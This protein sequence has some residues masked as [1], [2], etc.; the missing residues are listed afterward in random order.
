MAAKGELTRFDLV[1]LWNAERDKRGWWH[2]IELPDGT[3]IQGVCDL[4][5]Q[6]NRIAQFPIPQNLRGKRVLDIGAWDGWFSF[7]MERR[8]A[9]V[10]AIDNWDNP[11][12]H[13]AKALLNSRVEYR[14]MDV[15]ELTPARV[16]HFDIVLFMGVLYHLKHPLLAL[17]RVCALTTEMAAVD[18]FVLREKHR[19]GEKVDRLPVMEFYET[20]EFGGQTD[21]WV[22]PSLTCL[23]AFCRTAGF[24]RVELQ[25]VL[26]HSA[27]LACYRHWE[28][29]SAD[30]PEGPELV[31]AS[32][33]LSGGVNFDSSR[34]ELVSAWFRWKGRSLGLNDVRP[35]VGGYGVRPIH[36]AQAGENEW[37]TNFKLPPGLTPGCHDVR[38]RIGRSRPG[39]P[40]RIGVDVPLVARETQI[41]GVSDGTTRAKNQLD[42][43]R[44]ETNSMN[45]QKVVRE[46]HARMEQENGVES[47]SARESE[48]LTALRNAFQRLFQARNAVGQMPP[49]PNTIRAR[50]GKYLIR[51]VQRSLFWYTPQIVR[52]Q[53]E[54]SNALDC[55][56]NL[57]AWQL[58]RTA[59][60]ERD[61]QKLRGE[62]SKP[63][64]ELSKLSGEFSELRG[65]LSKL[66]LQLPLVRTTPAAAEHIR[67]REPDQEQDRPLPDA[68]QFA[69]QDRF[70]GSECETLEKLQPYLSAIETWMESLPQ[71][72]WLDI[73]CGR[74]E[75]LE[76][77]G[78]SG[79]SVVGIDSNPVAVA[80]CCARG[81]NAEET[82]ALGYLRSLKSESL[83][84][85]TAFHAVEH[86]SVGY[87]LALMQEAVRAL[88]P[89]G[90]MI[91]ET[92]NP[93]NLL[94]GSCNFWKD[95]TH[96]R[97]I[98]PELLEF[99]FQHFGLS[100]VK[101]L[102][103]NRSPQNERLP[104]D[105]ISTVH[106]LNES[107]YGPQDYGLIGRR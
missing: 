57:I 17:E 53:N 19:P 92:P 101:R 47:L 49:G 63:S 33:N 97:P 67:D 60:L 2:S 88:K 55:A 104:Y 77:V 41:Q 58:E 95:P 93:A 91:I 4:Q 26:E 83:A 84:V 16:G 54:A 30:A 40:Q 37:Q 11:R 89:D 24:A 10:L 50:I 68:F 65:E 5:G 107:L 21:T 39:S 79:Y 31:S 70:R 20:N 32:H 100:V 64:E 27:C 34:D 38:V 62:L 59:A 105:E 6:K 25:N 13:Q 106:R 51:A 76:A 48:E 99:V 74:G 81:L 56:C 12:F 102:D 73:G 36:V 78:A 87:F 15:Y 66:R 82:D 35:E 72:P 96:R 28:P 22:A 61:A 14:Q 42:L 8:G 75:W 1:Q 9:E 18:S 80:H 52:F 3:V 71:A 29:P 85:V 45:V 90:L 86:F 7:E 98:P 103:L 44:G 43:L 69:L 94:M 23:Q 46:I